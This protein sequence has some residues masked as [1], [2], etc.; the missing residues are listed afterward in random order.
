MTKTYPLGQLATPCCPVKSRGA[1]VASLSP[2]GLLLVIIINQKDP[3]VCVP[4]FLLRF[5]LSFFEAHCIASSQ[6]ILLNNV[7]E[8]N[9]LLKLTRIACSQDM[10]LG[11]PAETSFHLIYKYTSEIVL[12]S[13]P[14]CAWGGG[15]GRLRKGQDK[16]LM[17]HN[18]RQQS[19]HPL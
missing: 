3:R 1:L 18:N 10:V 14:F 12:V 7:S 13:Q 5:F 9:L 6:D 11:T 4:F 19:C 15:G 16:V 2:D 8:L 17:V